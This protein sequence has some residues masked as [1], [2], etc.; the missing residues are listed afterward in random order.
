MAAGR[1]LPARGIAA[2]LRRV[3]CHRTKRPY[4]SGNFGQRHVRDEQRGSER[5]TSV[6][7]VASV[8]VCFS[9]PRMRVKSWFPRTRCHGPGSPRVPAGRRQPKMV[10]RPAK[11]S[12]APPVDDMLFT[13]VGRLVRLQECANRRRVAPPTS[14]FVDRPH[15]SGRAEPRGAARSN[16]EEAR[17]IRKSIPAPSRNPPPPERRGGKCSRSGGRPRRRPST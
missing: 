7:D 1:R 9:R 2:E 15:V 5:T 13:T 12:D 6:I 11:I 8:T 16:M 10:R 3:P 17:R 4:L 14:E